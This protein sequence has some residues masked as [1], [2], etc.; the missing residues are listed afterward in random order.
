VNGRTLAQLAHL[1]WAEADAMLEGEPPAEQR[2]R[3][4]RM[5]EVR[6]LLL[7]SEKL[8]D[9]ARKAGFGKD[10]RDGADAAFG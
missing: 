2:V 8:M 3:L 7:I 5:R 1:C 4:R 9:R 6:R 10:G